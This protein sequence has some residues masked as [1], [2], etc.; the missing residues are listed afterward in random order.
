MPIA[1][2]VIGTIFLVA[3][4]RGKQDLLFATLKDDF[5]GPNNFIYWGV[6]I[7]VVTAIGYYRP[8]RPLSHGFLLLVFLGMFLG[9][10]KQGEAFIQKF[11]QQIAP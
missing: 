5:A 3:A 7:W 8:L 6:T 10:N 11:E 9:K 2:L 4:I 1:L